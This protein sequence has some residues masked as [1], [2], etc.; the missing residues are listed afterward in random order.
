MRH[1]PSGGATSDFCILGIRVYSPVA[2]LQP[3][4]G[5]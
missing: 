2:R 1:F 5:A 4:L 3:E